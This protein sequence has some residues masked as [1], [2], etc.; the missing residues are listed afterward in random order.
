M[1]TISNGFDIKIITKT[2]FI[3]YK[4]HYE[5]RH[6]RCPDIDSEVDSTVI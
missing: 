6:K 2:T 4:N 5:G 3:L 1:A